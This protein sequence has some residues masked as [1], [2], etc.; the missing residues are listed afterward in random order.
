MNF[1]NR[2]KSSCSYG[3]GIIHPLCLLFDGSSSPAEGN[4]VSQVGLGGTDARSC[5]F[6]KCPG[7]L[8]IKGMKAHTVSVL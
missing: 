3:D 7:G 1:K 6:P 5:P 4:I 2:E 8:A